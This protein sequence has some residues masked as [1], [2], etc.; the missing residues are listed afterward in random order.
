[1]S[2]MTN[3]RMTVAELIKALHEVPADAY[4]EQISRTDNDEVQSIGL[5]SVH[6]VYS[7]VI[8]IRIRLPRHER[9]HSY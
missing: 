9:T 1:M 2:L 4:V 7:P 3:G 8:E 5:D 6:I